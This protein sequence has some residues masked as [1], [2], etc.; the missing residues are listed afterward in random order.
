MNEILYIVLAV[1]ALFA[2]MQFWIR[3]VGMRKKGQSLHG[4]PG[5][6]GQEIDTGKKMLLY[7]Y[8]KTCGAC[9]AMTPVIEELQKEFEHI[10][11]VDLGKDMSVAREIGIMGTPTVVVVEN[12]EIQS[13]AVG[14]K[15]AAALRRLLQ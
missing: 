8:T 10:R 11:K 2:A 6:L 5:R 4:L 9:K 1:V 3:F 7:F 12:R 13:F 15:S 14:A